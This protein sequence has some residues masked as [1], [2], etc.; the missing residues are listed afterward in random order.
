[1]KL[2]VV[3]TAVHVNSLQQLNCCFSKLFGYYSGNSP[4]SKNAVVVII[5][6]K[7]LLNITQVSAQALKEDIRAFK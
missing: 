1:M 7:G 3:L 6:S 2:S 4:N 5:L